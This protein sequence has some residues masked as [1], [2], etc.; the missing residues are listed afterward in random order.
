[1][2]FQL[3][4]LLFPFSDGCLCCIY[5]TFELLPSL[6]ILGLHLAYGLGVLLL[7][8]EGLNLQPLDLVLLLQELCPRQLKLFGTSLELLQMCCVDRLLYLA[9]Q[10]LER[11]HLLHC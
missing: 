11:A 1:M 5:R 10:L 9:I 3:F 2:L 7:L 4:D 6:S 8:A